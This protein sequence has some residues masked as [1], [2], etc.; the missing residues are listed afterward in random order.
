MA[1]P[2]AKFECTKCGYVSYRMS[3]RPTGDIEYKGCPKCGGDMKITVTDEMPS[4]MAEVESLVDKNFT[5]VDFD[6]DRD[7]MYFEVDTADT[8]ASFR[9]L[10]RELKRNGYLAALRKRG[11]EFML[12]VARS[13]RV[14]GD[15]VL[16]NLGLIFATIATTFA[17]SYFFLSAGRATDAALFSGGLMIILG[18]H[19]MGH[20]IAAWRNGVASTLPYFIPAPTYLG[21]FGAF[22][23]VKSPIPTK[24]ALVEM[25]A[26]GPLLGFIFALPITIIGLALSRSTGGEFAIAS[27]LIFILLGY[28]IFGGVPAT[29][30]LH[31]LAFAGLIGMFVTWMNLIPA[32]QLDGGH[33]ARGMLN[34]QRHYSLTRM[35]GVTLIFLGLFMPALLIWGIIIMFL[36]RGQHPGAL[37]DVSEFSQRQRYLAWAAVAVFILCLPI[38]F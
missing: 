13:P 37:D 10:S 3:A 31:P 22:I 20:K 25:G 8:K 27:P 35:L 24:D 38:P 5:I 17:A 30:S 33:V 23:K 16:I 2:K 29:P 19:E 18:A 21:T 6:F 15:N 32:G 34:S 26:A 7:H 1:G 12:T 36:F 11:E 28:P 14:S 9:K 4:N